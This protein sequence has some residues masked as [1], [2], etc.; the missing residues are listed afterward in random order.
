MSEQTLEHNNNIA[1]YSY[2]RN[3]TGL[4]VRPFDIFSKTLK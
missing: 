1:P 3:C 4:S 2:N